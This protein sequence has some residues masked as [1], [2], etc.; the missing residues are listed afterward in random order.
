MFATVKSW[1]GSLFGDSDDG[2][3]LDRPKEDHQVKRQ[4]A[5]RKLDDLKSRREELKEAL[6]DKRSKYESA[7]EAGNEERAQDFLRDAEEIKEELE[8]VRGRID[9]TSK[10]RNLAS[11]LANI[12]EI[13]E[14]RGDD[15][16]SQLRE[17]DQSELVRLFQ[18]EEM[19]NE[20]L[21][22]VLGQT[23]T[24]S[25]NALD[26]FSE[27]ASQLHTGSELE[28]E[29]SDDTSE[30]DEEVSEEPTEVGN[31]ETESDVLSED[32]DDETV[33]FS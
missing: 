33:E 5:E 20:E 13:G 12:K 7:K 24:L 29:W 27:G 26:S 32:G 17:M 16:W 6:D 21:H 25:S 8:T 11:N 22:D 15:Y 31:I 30:T 28:E 3:L 10:Q 1:F 14:S 4:E 9:E 19:K 18:Q 2:H 23:D